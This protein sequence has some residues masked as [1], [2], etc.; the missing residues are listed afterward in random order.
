ML[1]GASKGSCQVFEDIFRLF[2]LFPVVDW[3]GLPLSPLLKRVQSPSTVFYLPSHRLL[4]DSQAHK[5]PDGND[6]TLGSLLKRKDAQ[7]TGSGDTPLLVEVLEDTSTDPNKSVT[8]PVLSYDPAVSR[9]VE[10]ALAV[11]VVALLELGTPVRE[12]AGVLREGIA[13]QLRAMSD[14]TLWKV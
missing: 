12:V 14:A 11:D 7:S 8:A 2:L 13:A 10:L 3:K 6:S 1:H 9:Q 5:H 4:L